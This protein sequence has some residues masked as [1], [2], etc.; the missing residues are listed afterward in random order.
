VAV[1]LGLQAFPALWS[2]F[3]RFALGALCVFAWAR[4]ARIPVM[5]RRDE[6]PLGIDSNFDHNT[7]H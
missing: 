1:K 7:L 6:W 5:P 3:L 2:G 4:Y